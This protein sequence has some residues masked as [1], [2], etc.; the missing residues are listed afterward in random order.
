MA[1]TLPAGVLDPKEAQERL[2]Q[3]YTREHIGAL[4][5]RS[6]KLAK[7]IRD[8]TV[9]LEEIDSFLQ[10]ASQ[11]P[12]DLEEYLL[13]KKAWLLS[14]QGHV[15]EGLE[16]YDAALEINEE[17]PS[18][19]ALKGAALLQLARLNEAF[20]AFQKAY[21]F[22]ENFGRQK[23]GYLEDL[24][25]GW[26]T[27]SLFRGLLGIL[28]QDSR[29]AQKGVDEYLLVLDKARAENLENSIVKLVAQEPGSQELQ[30][31][32]EELELMIRLLSIKNPFDRWRAFTKEISKVWPKD[33]SAVDAIREQRDRE[34]NK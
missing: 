1:M 25:G 29:E 9:T 20:Q 11:L 33:I 16:Q 32:L 18:T 17:S 34:W 31:A 22:K 19:W 7:S 24:F 12:P 4:E 5:P 13:C 23:Q 26:S 21:S 2:E 6:S 8:G 14:R 28:D 15:E 10:E 27:A 3:A 30:E